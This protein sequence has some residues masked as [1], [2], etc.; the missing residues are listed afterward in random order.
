MATVRKLVTK[1]S[2]DA[3]LSQAN[4]FEGIINGLKKKV[5]ELNKA[6]QAGKVRVPTIK[7]PKLPRKLAETLKSLKEKLKKS[8]LGEF[9]EG[10]RKKIAESRVGQAI[11]K[12]KKKIEDSKIG[13]AF[14]KLKDDI[15]D[16]QVVKA[17]TTFTKN[18]AAAV[19]KLGE[20][21]VV[22][23]KLAVTAIGKAFKGIVDTIRNNKFKII[24]LVAATV[25][26]IKKA[27]TEAATV[28]ELTVF[29]ESK[30]GI[31]GTKKLN[32]QIQKA[33]K[34]LRIGEMFK[35]EEIKQALV[36]ALKLGVEPDLIAKFIK[37]A[38]IIAGGTPGLTFG[39][40]F[41]DLTRFTFG[42]ATEREL[43]KLGLFSQKEIEAGKISKRL[44]GDVV[45]SR[46]AQIVLQ[47][48]QLKRQEGIKRLDKALLTV[49]AKQKQ[50]S[51]EISGI[52]L[53]IG[54]A[55]RTDVNQA[56]T[57]TLE[58]MRAI[59]K[60]GFFEG[61]KTFI[62][63]IRESFKAGKIKEI[64][65]PLG[66][67]KIKQPALIPQKPPIIA[68]KK[69]KEKSLINKIFGLQLNERNKGEGKLT[70]ETA[71]LNIPPVINF[72]LPAQREQL[73]TQNITQNITVDGNVVDISRAEQAR[74]YKQI[75]A[76]FIGLNQMKRGQNVVTT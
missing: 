48:L 60:E 35:A 4:K 55:I 61:A 12:I 66:R 46:K 23:I 25:A 72:Q 54:N 13:R 42:G 34:D 63:G 30:F 49:V 22:P 38:F 56:L 36:T 31:E 41:L 75:Q 5:I 44:A 2:F 69:P 53:D 62:E 67:I 58:L 52:F 27:I 28:E 26:G 14:R 15:K 70:T 45:N 50:I 40:A 21:V 3:D 39:E 29:I 71:S 19:K 17:I 68:P 43:T 6:L 10:L 7:A 37:D 8:G 24:A 18:A 32:A 57:E 16:A 51:G 47:A 9:Y 20:T 59:R 73:I 74:V 76:G 11:G 1:L 33:K 65:S 64:L